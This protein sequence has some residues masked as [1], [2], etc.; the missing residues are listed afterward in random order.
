MNLKTKTSTKVLLIEDRADDQKL[1]R[2]FLEN[3][4]HKNSYQVSIAGSSAEALKA[5]KAFDKHG[6]EIE[7]FQPDFDVVLLDFDLGDGNGLQLMPE[8]LAKNLAVI[9]VAGNKLSSIVIEAIRAGAYD[10][11]VKE[12]EEMY[13]KLLPN[14][15]DTVV[16]R[17]KQELELEQKTKELSQ[18]NEELKSF[19]HVV[20]HD[21][22]APLRHIQTLS[23]FVLEDH[24]NKLT[25]DSQENLEKV[26]EIS[27][28]AMEM[29]KAVLDVSQVNYED[30]KKE[31]ISSSDVIHDACNMLEIPGHIRVIIADHIHDVYYSKTHL[32]QVFQN[33]ISNAVKYMDKEEGTIFIS[34]RLKSNGREIEFCVKDNGPGIEEIYLSELFRIFNTCG[35]KNENAT[36]VGLTIVKK[37]VERHNGSVHVSSKLGSGSSFFFTVPIE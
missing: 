19:A 35:V 26:K 12:R 21:L 10:Y 8:L 5:I 7:D 16:K 30:V 1:T 13:L 34:S 37:I 29:V 3:K 27:L 31:K 18:I 9:F 24:Q 4:E 32:Q 22:K 23:Y 15:I 33:L 17:K 11:I 6:L 2:D 14:R 36:G 28:K 20:S 25:T